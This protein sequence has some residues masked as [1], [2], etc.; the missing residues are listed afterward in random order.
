MPELVRPHGNVRRMFTLLVHFH[1]PDPASAA[2]FDALVAD[3]VPVIRQRE[4]GTLTY[5]SY[6]VAD[7]PLT[8]VFFEVYRDAAAHAEHERQPHTREFLDR[9]GRL[10]S[11]IRVEKL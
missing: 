9:I 10:V 2:A 8:R 6:A 4:A 11:S 5:D 7:E 3:T 1:L